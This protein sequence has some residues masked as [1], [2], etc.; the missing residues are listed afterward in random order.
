[1]FSSHTLHVL[2]IIPQKSKKTIEQIKKN[3][4][5]VWINFNSAIPIW[6][7]FRPKNKV[8]FTFLVDSYNN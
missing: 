1:M 3:I 6:Y 7:S 4:C 8:W 2:Q 5:P